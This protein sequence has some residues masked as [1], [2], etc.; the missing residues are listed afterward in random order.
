MYERGERGLWVKG[1]A[2]G[3][4]WRDSGRV[5]I[6]DGA[7]EGEEARQRASL[8]SSAADFTFGVGGGGSENNMS[9]LGG[10]WGGEEARN[11]ILKG[12]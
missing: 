10:T 8:F 5:D 12:V 3:V 4:V 6:T 1:Q 2:K 11:R 7:G 9:E